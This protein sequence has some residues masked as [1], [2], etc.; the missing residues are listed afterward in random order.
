[1]I[2]VL[3][4]HKAEIKMSKVITMLELKHLSP[5]ELAAM[6]RQIRDALTRSAAGSAERRNVLASLENVNRVLN[7][8]RALK[9]PSM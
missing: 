2:G 6:Q 7:M 1:M 5:S 8:R 3:G 4:D 9:P